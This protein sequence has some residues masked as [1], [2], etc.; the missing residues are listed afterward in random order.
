[1][2]TNPLRGDV[3]SVG[4]DGSSL[5]NLTRT[6][7]AWE[8]Q[9]SVSPDGLHVAFV[10]SARPDRGGRLIVTDAEG[11]RARDLG[12]AALSPDP[13]SPPAWS[14]NGRSIAFTNAVGCD[15]VVCKTWEVWLAN[16]V[17]GRRR[18]LTTHGM[19]PSWAPDG[20]RLVYGGNLVTGFTAKGY[21]KF[22]T[23]VVVENLASGSTR[24]LGRGGA[25]LWAPRGDWIA[26]FANPGGALQVVHGDGSGRRVVDRYAEAP[27]WTRGGRLLFVRNPPSGDVAQV[28]VY[29]PG[30][31]RRKARP[32]VRD[33]NGAFALSPDGRRLAWTRFVYVRNEAR[34]HDDLLVG[35]AT[36]RG[37]RVVVTGDPPARIGSVAWA[38]RG[39]IVFS[40]WRVP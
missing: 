25:P 37:G 27:Q 40:A 30:M 20:R 24:T 35:S 39:R 1:M 21:F 11:Q 2:P 12:P 38:P 17:T 22:S 23:D 31:R 18:R 28:D 3:F 15:E 26:Y 33:A 9:V 7:R 5:R 4:A 29:A 34:S 8:S 6:Q 36:R 13:T 10:R 14:P 16:V 19:D 32:L